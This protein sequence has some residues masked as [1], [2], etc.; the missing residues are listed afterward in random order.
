MKQQN[1]AACAVI[2]RNEYKYSG[3]SLYRL[4]NDYKSIPDKHDIRL[5]KVGEQPEVKKLGILFD[6]TG[7]GA[8]EKAKI[9]MIELLGDKTQFE[10]KFVEGIANNRMIIN[11]TVER[12]DKD[13]YIFVIAMSAFDTYTRDSVVVETLLVSEKYEDLLNDV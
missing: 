13:E 6:I 1:E 4:Y 12:P 3:F 8:V 2:E 7:A 10:G 5:L 11:F 9:H